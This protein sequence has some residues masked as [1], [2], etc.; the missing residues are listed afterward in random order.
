[1]SDDDKSY[2]DMLDECKQHHLKLKE[3]VP[4]MY[5]K[6]TKEGVEPDQAKDRIIK[7]LLQFGWNKNY[8]R[9]LLPPESKDETLSKAAKRKGKAQISVPEI[10]VI[11]GSSGTAAEP[12]HDS[13]ERWA[14]EGFDRTK[15][16]AEPKTCNFIN[17]FSKASETS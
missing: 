13:Y 2:D 3:L 15:I 12:E 1:M 8:I 9:D 4:R 16:I 11:A 7:D 14:E 10:A 5:D 6:L 17:E